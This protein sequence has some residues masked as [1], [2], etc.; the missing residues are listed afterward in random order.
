VVQIELPGSCP[1]EL[2]SGCKPSFLE[3]RTCDFLRRHRNDPFVLYVNFLEPHPPYF[4][5]LDNEHATDAVDLPINFSD[6]LESDE[7]LRYRLMKDR[8]HGPGNKGFDFSSEAGWRRLIANYW[9]LVIQVDRSVGGI[10]KAVEDLGLAENTI[11]V[12]TSDHGDMM[13][14]HGMV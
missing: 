6:P 1:A 7:P 2:T 5:P 9:G 13:G 11:V 10:L 12:Y 3:T 8:Q 4:G 14:S